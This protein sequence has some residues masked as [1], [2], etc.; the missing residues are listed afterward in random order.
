MT[1]LDPQTAACPNCGCVAATQ[2][3]ACSDPGKCPYWVPSKGWVYRDDITPADRAEIKAWEPPPLRYDRNYDQCGTPPFHSPRRVGMMWNGEP[4]FM[5]PA[6]YR[7]Y[8][9]APASK[10]DYVKVPKS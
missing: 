3:H 7:N 1:D 4:M 8:F 9:G 6:C 10:E 2:F 5:C